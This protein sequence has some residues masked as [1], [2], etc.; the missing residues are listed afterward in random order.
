M[1]TT[2]LCYILSIKILAK[3]VQRTMPKRRGQILNYFTVTD[4]K[5]TKRCYRWNANYHCIKIEIKY[6]RGHWYINSNNY[7]IWMLS[8]TINNFSNRSR[9]VS[10]PVDFYH[11][12]SWIF[13]HYFLLASIQYLTVTQNSLFLMAAVVRNSTKHFW[14]IHNPFETET[15]AH[16]LTSKWPI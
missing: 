11:Y 7:T 4:G 5:G 15:V 16:N 8:G 13:H 9:A 12:Q 14:C 10:C 3:L 2:R 1:V 6:L